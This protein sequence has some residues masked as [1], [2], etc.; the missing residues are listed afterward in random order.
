MCLYGCGLESEY[1]V[2]RSFRVSVQIDQDVDAV[3]VDDLGG[4]PCVQSYHTYIQI[5]ICLYIRTVC[6]IDYWRIDCSTAD[7]YDMLALGVDLRPGLRLVRGCERVAVHLEAGR[8]VLAEYRPNKLS[9]GVVSA[10]V[11]E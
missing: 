11:M 3:V 1:F 5:C 10:H 6:I 4:I 9:C 7:I 2:F 8:V